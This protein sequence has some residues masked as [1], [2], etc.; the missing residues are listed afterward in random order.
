MFLSTT[1][2]DNFPTTNLESLACGTPVITF[3]TGGSPEAINDKTGL[4]TKEKNVESLYLAIKSMKNKDENKKHCRQRAEK[5]YSKE[6]FSKEYLKLF[7]KT[8]EG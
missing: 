8:Y 4:V 2:D 7:Q 3:N 1:L 6:K 5:Y